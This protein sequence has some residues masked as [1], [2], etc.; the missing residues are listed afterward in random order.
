MIYMS[1]SEP[2]ILAITAEITKTTVLK[3]AML[4]PKT[5]VAKASS[6]IA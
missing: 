6:R 3:S 1:H 2:E 5:S 4:Y